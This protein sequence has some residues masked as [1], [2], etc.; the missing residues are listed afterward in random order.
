MPQTRIPLVR[1]EVEQLLLKNRIIE[2]TEVVDVNLS[3]SGPSNGLEQAARRELFGKIFAAA[4]RAERKDDVQFIRLHFG[5]ELPT[6]PLRDVLPQVS[7]DDPS[8]VNR[9]GFDDEP[10]LT[11]EALALANNS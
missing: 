10:T 4:A 11:G 6:M 3:K 2:A 7:P 9:F 1:R 8:I 5:D